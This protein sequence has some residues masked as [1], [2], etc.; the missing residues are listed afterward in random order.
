[1]LLE[2]GQDTRE[3]GKKTTRITREFTQTILLIKRLEQ[4]DAC[5]PTD[6][7]VARE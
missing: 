4:K 5:S 2:K 7:H 6:S 1:M 3:V